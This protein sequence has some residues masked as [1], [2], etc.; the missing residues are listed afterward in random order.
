MLTCPE[1]LAA[2]IWLRLA[3]WIL[4]TSSVGGRSDPSFQHCQNSRLL[5][6]ARYSVKQEPVQDCQFPPNVI[7]C[8]LP[9]QGFQ[10]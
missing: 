3:A 4:V 10:I 1:R 8:C 7:L 5:F 9:L 2:R 6:E